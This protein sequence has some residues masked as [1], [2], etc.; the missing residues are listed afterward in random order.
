MLNAAKQFFLKL[1]LY[2]TQ[3]YGSFALD[4]WTASI[5]AQAHLCPRCMDCINYS[6]S[7]ALP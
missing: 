5:T 2:Y 6:P 4:V 7:L 1:L 3:P